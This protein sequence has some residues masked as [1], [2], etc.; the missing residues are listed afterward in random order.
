M[1]TNW[2]CLS[3]AIPV[4]TH[5]ICVGA[6]VTNLSPRFSSFFWSYGKK[7]KKNGNEETLKGL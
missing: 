2:N 5:K 7:K 3:E 1:G 4:S 6:K